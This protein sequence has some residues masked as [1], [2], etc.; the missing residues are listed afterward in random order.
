MA[1]VH[2]VAF[3]LVKKWILQFR[4]REI[5][6]LLVIIRYCWR[7]KITSGRILSPVLEKEKKTLGHM[8]ESLLRILFAASLDGRASSLE[9]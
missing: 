1:A 4:M 9:T 2:N 6:V 7:G 3:L 8:E 5:I